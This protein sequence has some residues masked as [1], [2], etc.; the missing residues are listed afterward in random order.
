MKNEENT[1]A[2]TVHS[3]FFM[4][5]LHNMKVWYKIES[6]KRSNFIISVDTSCR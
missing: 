5:F 3:L 1:N 2:N 4:V 6:I